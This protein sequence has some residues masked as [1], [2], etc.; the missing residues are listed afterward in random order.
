VVPVA[1]AIKA[2]AA[3]IWDLM[4]D[5]SDIIWQGLSWLWNK[6]V[7]GVTWLSN[8][9]TD[10]FAMVLGWGLKTVATIRD[11]FLGVLNAI[12]TPPKETQK[13]VEEILENRSQG[14]AAWPRTC[15]TLAASWSSRSGL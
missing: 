12:V 15:G 4:K 11:T 3:V 14:R 1:N 6:V 10:L 5:L 2:A 9:V 7:S 13:E 8:K